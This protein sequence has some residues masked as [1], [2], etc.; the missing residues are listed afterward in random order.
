MHLAQ[1]RVQRVGGLFVEIAGRLVGQQHR[2]R[3]IKARATATRCCSPPD[4]MPG[5]CASRSREPD[6]REQLLGAR[7]RLGHRHA[8]NAHRHLGVLE[9]AELRQQMMKLEDEA[10]AL[11]PEPDER[12][13]VE[14][15]STGAPSIATVPFVGPIEPAQ[16][17][18]QRALADAGRADNRHHLARLD[19]QI[20]IAQ[21]GQRRPADRV[22]LDDSARFE[23]W[24]ARHG[25]SHEGT[26]ATKHTKTACTNK[27]S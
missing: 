5:R 12:G 13:I 24:H 22:A 3:M 27:A 11:V 23:E 21:H 8:R 25:F 26:K 19:L 4:S 10:D 6:A 7:P 17:V 18:Q 9:R 20:E 16:D 2:G 1:Q 15:T 14:R